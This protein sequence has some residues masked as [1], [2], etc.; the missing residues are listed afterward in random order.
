MGLQVGHLAATIRVRPRSGEHSGVGAVRVGTAVS[1]GATS[2]LMGFYPTIMLIALLVGFGPG[3][4]ETLASAAIAEYVFME[5][6]KLFALK[7]RFATA[8]GW[9]CFGAA[10]VT[11]SWLGDR[12]RRR[13]MRLQEF[14][15]AV[16]GLEEMVLVWTATTAT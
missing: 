8:S 6:L 7:H 16:E 10:G 5:L 4:S 13:A 15:E 14:E 12:F 11:I 2:A 9:H 1:V 3:L